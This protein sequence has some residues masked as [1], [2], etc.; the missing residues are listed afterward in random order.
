MTDAED[1]AKMDMPCECDCGNWFDL[2]EGNP[3]DSC[4]TVSC[5]ECIESPW[6]TCPRCKG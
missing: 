6:D 2:Q 4:D 1:I 3:C 5:T